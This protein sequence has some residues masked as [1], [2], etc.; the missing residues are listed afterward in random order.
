MN[1]NVS[2]QVWALTAKAETKLVLLALIAEADDAGQAA[3]G[4]DRLAAITGLSDRG[5]RKILDRLQVAG[6]IKVGA[7]GLG[8]GKCNTW[9]IN[10][11]LGSPFPEET[12]TINTESSSP[13]PQKGEPDSPFTGQ[14]GEAGSPFPSGT[15]LALIGTKNNKHIKPTNVGLKGATDRRHKPTVKRADDP[16][17]AIFCSEYVAAGLGPGYAYLAQDFIQLAR[18]RTRLASAKPDP[19]D[20]TEALFTIACK[21]Y[22]Q[23]DRS[24]WTLADLA[25]N[26]T[27][28]MRSAID[29]FNQPKPLE[30]GTLCNGNQPKSGNGNRRETHNER[31]ARQTLELVAGAFGKG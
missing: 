10:P 11:E 19:I 23:S 25:V 17:F 31:A 21:N 5:I 22:F 24:K 18:M 16:L 13:F 26:V 29:R 28:F 30:N 9:L 14:K 7:H 1:P 20:L 3:P 27:T 12:G 15:E 2:K 6:L 8:R 4:V